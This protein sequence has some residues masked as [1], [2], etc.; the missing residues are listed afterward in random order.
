M[1]VL[2]SLFGPLTFILSPRICG[3]RGVRAVCSIS[4]LVNERID[5]LWQ[6]N[7]SDEHRDFFTMI[8]NLRFTL[9]R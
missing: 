2:Q 7:I 5:T 3:E 9:M 1:R 8:M 6:G 4:F